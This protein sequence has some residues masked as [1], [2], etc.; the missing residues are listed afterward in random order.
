MESRDKRAENMSTR[1][2]AENR[3]TT[4]RAAKTS[5]DS[6][7]EANRAEI[8]GKKGKIKTEHTEPTGNTSAIPG[9]D[10][11]Q[12]GSAAAGAGLGDNKGT[13]TRNKK[14]FT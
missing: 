9:A 4:D 8:D 7:R 14:D 3:A 5:T 13:G 2:G 12:E 6:T 1:T 11:K 10:K